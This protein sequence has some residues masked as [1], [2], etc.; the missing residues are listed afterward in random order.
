MIYAEMASYV[1]EKWYLSIDWSR[2]S[3]FAVVKP[4]TGSFWGGGVEEAES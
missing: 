2:I 1:Y 4:D 3:D